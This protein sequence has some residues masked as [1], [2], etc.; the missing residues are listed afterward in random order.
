MCK[1]KNSN[2]YENQVQKEFLK[3]NRLISEIISNSTPGTI[4]IYDLLNS[5]FIKSLEK[6]SITADDVSNIIS[7]FKNEISIIIP[8][9]NEYDNVKKS[10]ESVFNNTIMDFNLILIDD[11]STDS[12]ISSLLTQYEEYDNVFIIRNAYK[13]GFSKNIN[14]GISL[15]ETDVI[16]LSS[17]VIVTP[18]WDQKLVF[19][20]YSNPKIGTVMPFSNNTHSS[21]Q[22]IIENYKNSNLLNLNEISNLV[23][24]SSYNWKL[25]TPIYN[26]SCLFI[27]RAALND[28]GSFDEIDS[29]NDFNELINFLIRL[30]KNGW[31][32]ILNDS[33]FIFNNQK[34]YLFS[35]TEELKKKCE[36]INDEEYATTLN[37]IQ[38]F[39][40]SDTIKK[41]ISAINHAL[42]NFN[43]DFIKKNILYI[44]NITNNQP[45]IDSFKNLLKNV[46]VF[47]LTLEESKMK[48]WY[49]KKGKFFILKEITFNKEIPNIS[50]LNTIYTYIFNYLK[51]DFTFIRFCPQL[52]PDILPNVAP[53]FFSDK[54][55]I[56]ILYGKCSDDLI[57]Q[58]NEFSYF[59]SKKVDFRKEKGVI[60]TAIFGD[61][62]S[63]LNPK[64]INPYL[65]YICF[66]DNPNLT[67]DV[68]EIRLI[69]NLD[70]DN[71]RKARTIKI[72]P[73]K[74]L[75]EYDFSIW[76]DAGFQ[77]IGDMENYVNTYI[78]EG[79]LIGVKHSVRNCI[80]EEIDVCYSRDK[81]DGSILKTII[82][83]YKSEGYP[84]NNGLIESGVL[85]R[86]HNNPKII[87]LMEQ[88]HYEVM[89]YSKRDQL[90][91][92]YVCWKN[93]FHYDKADIYCWKNQY[94]EHFMH[95]NN[96]SNNRLTVKQFRVIL[97]ANS[98]S[99]LTKKSLNS[100]N[101]INDNIPISIIS[102]SDY[103][104][105][106]N[107]N[108]NSYKLNLPNE[109]IHCINDIINN[110]EE[111]FI[112]IICSGDT[113]EYSIIE[114][115]N[116]II[117]NST[118]NNIAV[119]LLSDYS[120]I[121]ENISNNNHNQDNNNGILLNRK[122]LKSN[123]SFNSHTQFIDKYINK[124]NDKYEISDWKKN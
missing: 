18:K 59:K 38:E 29:N 106:N 32:N 48:L 4:N 42:N 78:Q 109:S 55:K 116:T 63:L 102:T 60:Y 91:F 118:F 110:S 54:I 99:E 19:S 121:Q 8:I 69:T 85:F 124:I 105:Y 86:R 71:T 49:Y 28:V 3:L 101:N 65:D 9:Y 123:G 89:N 67:S 74:Y 98:D 36:K 84:K 80:Y 82:N 93:N 12:R 40:N 16:I 35:N 103:S 7:A 33:I 107:Y 25:E 41:S 87:N 44:T 62:E 113:I 52:Q 2:E 56:P 26:E 75:K 51:I 46:N 66:T 37:E 88:W 94:F 104:N 53:L 64:V 70:M 117:N 45:N 76:V 1:L 114:K 90:S 61:Y 21:M 58:I 43:D 79:L 39:T 11:C 15:Y 92:N 83:R 119:C 10:L 23:E 31:K 72:L 17:N 100:I 95:I 47:P 120:Y 30:N 122:I 81:D 34:E 14:M 73:H 77:I 5:N 57:N 97:I 6:Q 108:I 112:H 24:N 22:N 50:Q 68:W 13:K 27:K 20:A 115:L 111:E 96:V